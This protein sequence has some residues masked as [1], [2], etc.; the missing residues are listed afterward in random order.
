MLMRPAAD[1]TLTQF[2]E[3]YVNTGLQGFSDREI[4]ELFFSLNLPT[5][6]ASRL[7]DACIEKYHSLREFLSAPVSQLQRLGIPRS[8]IFSLKLIHELPVRILKEEIMNQ[9]VFDSP[10]VIFNYLYYSMRDLEKE[11]FKV[12]YLNARKQ[13]IDVNDLFEGSAE[14]ISFSAR[15]V[16][17]STLEHDAKSLVIVHNHP[18]GDPS[19]S[20]ADKQLTRDMVFVSSILHIKALD[21]IIIGNN[22]FFSFADEGFIKEYEMDFLNLKLTGTH[23][24][25]RRLSE[26]RDIHNKTDDQTTSELT[27][28]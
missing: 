22:C 2:Q 5:D 6:V 17:E 25:K 12:I 11:V 13:I 16:V 10:Q 26:A 24:A 14:K 23:E 18:S 27:V 15:E 1:G 19:P 4:I 28:G 7:A 3:R 21:H 8:C 9:P 20:Q